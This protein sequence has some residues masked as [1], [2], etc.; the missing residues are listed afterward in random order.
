[1]HHWLRGMDIECPCFYLFY[2]AGFYWWD[3]LYPMCVIPIIQDAC[4]L[5]PMCGRNRR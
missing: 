5:Y 1:M 4:S 2:T 3:S